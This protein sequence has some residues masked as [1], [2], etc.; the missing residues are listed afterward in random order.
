MPTM[1]SHGQGSI[2]RRKTGPPYQVSIALTGGRRVY[3]YAHSLR[4]AEK[5]RRELVE[6][7]ESDRDPSRLTVAD[8]LRSWITGLRDARNQRVRP[9]TLEH[10]TL[11]VERHIIPALGRHRLPALRESH[12]QSWLD[13][14]PGSPRTVHHHRAVLRRALNVAVGQ[15]LLDRNPALAVELPD[16]TYTGAR[17]LTFEEGRAVLQATAND[18]LHALWRLAVMTG[19]RQSE[20]LGLGW[21]DLGLDAGT[22]N[23]TSQLQRIGGA[24]ARTATKAHRSLHLL[25]LDPTTVAALREHQRRMAA[26]RTAE[27]E[28][29]GLLFTTPRGQPITNHVV[30]REWH[31][32]CDKAGISRRRFHDLRHSAAQLMDDLGVAEDVRMARFGHNTTAMARR[33]AKGSETQ[34]RAA[35][36]A[37]ERALAG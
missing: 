13:S 19:L 15:R 29:F 14:D 35:V 16:A 36:E 18:R 21:D 3:R 5:V 2:T 31:D 34:D 11:I 17:P 7:R 30:L 10:Y 37:L 32:A 6:M 4:E 1:G 22:V 25:A 27:W 23:V 24:W 33:Y 8:F 26:E 12:V 9:R 20:L 28:Y